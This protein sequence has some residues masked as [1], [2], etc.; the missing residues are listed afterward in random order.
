MQDLRQS[1]DTQIKSVLNED[2]QKNFDKMREE[3]AD[4]MKKWHKGGDNAPPA[5]DCSGQSAVM[6]VGPQTSDLGEWRRV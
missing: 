1:S 4:R 6:G 5:G 2:Q 3:Q